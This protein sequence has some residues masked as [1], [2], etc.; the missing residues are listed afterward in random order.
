MPEFPLTSAYWPAQTFPPLRETTI[1]SILGDAAACAPNKI[2]L[3][4]GNPVR[5][6]R[7]QW[8]YLALLA[9]AERAARALLALAEQSPG[10][11]GLLLAVILNLTS[12][13]YLRSALLA[14]ISRKGPEQK[15]MEDLHAYGAMPLS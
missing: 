15:I 8:T 1:G 5:A 11:D 10:P 2:A 6:K 4:D 14:V 3:I 9:D 12:A 13:A 7:R